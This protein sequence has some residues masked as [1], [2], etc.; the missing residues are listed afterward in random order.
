[1]EYSSCPVL[2]V[3]IRATTRQNLLFFARFSVQLKTKQGILVCG[4]ATPSPFSCLFVPFVGRPPPPLSPRSLI[5]LCSFVS[6]C[7]SS[8]PIHPVHP[9]ILSRERET[10]NGHKW[11]PIGWIRMHSCYYPPESPFQLPLCRP[12]FTARGLNGVQFEE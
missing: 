11:T 2:S 5:Y 4:C 9:V 7:G 6:I 8:S 12:A 10:T 1:M 3:P